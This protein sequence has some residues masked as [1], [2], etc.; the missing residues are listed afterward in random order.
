MAITQSS[1][2]IYSVNRVDSL[3]DNGQCYWYHLEFNNLKFKFTSKITTEVS[4]PDPLNAW[5]G[6]CFTKMII[7]CLTFNLIC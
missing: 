5:F 2:G 1:I 6:L 4:E 3:I 7:V